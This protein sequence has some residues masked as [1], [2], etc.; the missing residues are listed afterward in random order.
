MRNAF[1]FP[2]QGSQRP[3]M[4]GEVLGAGDG[5]REVFVL[6]NEICGSDLV[7]LCDKGDPLLLSRTDYCQIGV[8]ATSLA[9][10]ELLRRRGEKPHA[11]AGHSLGEYCAACAAGCMSV[12]D[13]LRLVWRRGQ[14]M[15]ECSRETPGGMLALVGVGWE[16]ARELLE[17][18]G[19]EGRVAFANLNSATQVVLAGDPDDLRNT[20]AMLRA[21]GIRSVPLKVSG[22]FHTPAMARAREAVARYLETMPL[23]DPSLTFFSAFTGERVRTAS[24]V[25]ECLSSGITSPVRW[26]E[27]Q[28][29]LVENGT[30]RQ[31]EVGP[32]DV[33]SRMGSV[34]HP[35]VLFVRAAEVTSG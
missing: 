26:L 1:V 4:A 15:L 20:A 3:G 10:L 6:A 5:A 33:L 35:H 19:V 8:A 9:W 29:R 12:E 21:R 34:D 18:S 7:E 31:V 17:E 25:A 32:G 27:V 16:A 24:E 28:S 11:V 30:E 2:G 13:C 14:A 22:A 23:R